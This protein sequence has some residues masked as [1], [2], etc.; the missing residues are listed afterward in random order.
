MCGGFIAVQ[1]NLDRASDRVW[2]TGTGR[3]AIRSFPAVLKFHMNGVFR[4]HFRVHLGFVVPLQFNETWTVLEVELVLQTLVTVHSARLAVPT[5][6]YA[7][8]TP[9]PLH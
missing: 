8:C 2:T 6:S 1:R 3:G 4:L 7:R 9:G 5:L